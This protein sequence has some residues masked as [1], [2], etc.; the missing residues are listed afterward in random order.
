MLR[1]R[2]IGRV[3]GSGSKGYGDRERSR[4][5]VCVVVWDTRYWFE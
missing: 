5:V 4:G 2:S 3:A 1:D